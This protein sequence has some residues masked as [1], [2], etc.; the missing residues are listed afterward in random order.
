M[1]AG[2][3]FDVRLDSPA[4]GDH[5]TAACKVIEGGLGIRAA[6][7]VGGF[8][9]VFADDATQA[10]RLA[11]A[12]DVKI[13]TSV[14]GLT[15]EPWS[16]FTSSG[17]DYAF[18]ITDTRIGLEDLAAFPDSS[19]W[20]YDDTTWDVSVFPVSPPTVRLNVYGS[21]VGEGDSA[22]AYMELARSGGIVGD[23]EVALF[24]NA[25]AGD[26]DYAIYVDGERLEGDAVRIPHG[27]D[28]VPLS[29]VPLEDNI[30]ESFEWVEVYLKPDP[31][32][33]Y[34][35]GGRDSITTEIADNDDYARVWVTH[36][37][38]T[39]EG[40][41]YGV[42]RLERNLTEEPLSLTITVNASQ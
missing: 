36:E 19:D 4:A 23:L 13:N 34:D 3:W 30:V 20:N 22:G 15:P 29:I 25:T 37:I 31:D 40:G 26:A 2:S 39:E 32:G 16:S 12:G 6:V 11:L 21:R 17:P 8:A 10:V 42:V 7:D 41:E 5:G 35:L 9:R 28:F 24:V 18:H 1:P 38:D 27:R 14:V 33:R